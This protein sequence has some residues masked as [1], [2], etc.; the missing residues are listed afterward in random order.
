MTF[1]AVR[2]LSEVDT[3]FCEDTR[4]SK[5]LLDHFEIKAKLASYHKFNEMSRI[6][7]IIALASEGKN[8][9]IISDAGMPAIS[10]PGNILVK[11]LIDQG[12]DYTVLPGATAFTTALVLSG[13][14]SY[15]FSFLGF[16]PSKSGEKKRFVEKL[17]DKKETLIFY[18]SPHRVQETVATFAEYMPNRR[19]ALV[20]EISKI[21]EQV[22]IFEAKDYE[23]IEIVEKGE[24]VILLDKDDQVIEITDQLIIENL[25]AVMATGMSKKMAVKEVA[26]ELEI[27]KNRVYDL[28]LNM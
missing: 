26:K 7:E 23:S 25:E 20:R 8:L 12:I 3:I 11:A 14:D 17:V 21:Y 2:V 18:E 22:L 27:N 4:T 13:F 19:V 16:L 24:Y 5:R 10:D 1:R 15:N 28:S 9:A 6:D